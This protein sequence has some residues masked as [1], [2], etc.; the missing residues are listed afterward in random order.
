MCW[1]HVL[2]T[3]KAP[4]GHWVRAG[5]ANRPQ[6]G[7]NAERARTNPDRTIS[8]PISRDAVKR[9]WTTVWVCHFLPRWVPRGSGD[10]KDPECQRSVLVRYQRG[11]A[12]QCVSRSSSWHLKG[13]FIQW[14]QVLLLIHPPQPFR[15]RE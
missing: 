2:P 9:R 13:N 3:A 7:A 1:L 12:S 14:M 8:R 11:R 10:Q 15:I 6:P 4:A 5:D